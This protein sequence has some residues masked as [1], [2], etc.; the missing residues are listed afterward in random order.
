MEMRLPVIA[1]SALLLLLGGCGGGGQGAAPGMSGPAAVCVDP[2]TQSGVLDILYQNL[3]AASGDVFGEAVQWVRQSRPLTLSMVTFEGQNAQTNEITCRG[4]LGANNTNAS[5]VLT[6]SRKQAADGQG[7]VYEI[8]DT[9]GGIQ[10]LTAAVVARQQ[11]RNNE[12]A[13]RQEAANTFAERTP[14]PPPPLPVPATDTTANPGSNSANSASTP[15]FADY[16]VARTFYGEHAQPDLSDPER[17]GF[18]TRLREAAARE[19]NFA[20][21][22]VLTTWGCGTSCLTGAV[23]NPESGQVVWLPGSV[24]CAANTDADFNPI[25]ARPG[26]RLLVMSGVLNES[27]PD[28]ARFYAFDGQSF[29]LVQSVLR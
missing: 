23:V 15:R 10:V 16:A 17:W 14:T 24:C 29:N 22:W 18:R 20:G 11:A 21:N 9:S 25:E 28:A 6:Y 7:Y 4:S 13:A 12:A 8:A 19:P 5:T 3:P 2:Q 26:S 27:G 1:C